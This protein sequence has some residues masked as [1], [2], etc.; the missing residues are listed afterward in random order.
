MEKFDR[1]RIH[2]EIQLKAKPQKNVRG[3]LVRR[4][5]RIAERS[6]KNG[7]EFVAEH[8]DRT[9]GKCDAFAQEFIGAP[10][11]FDKLNLSACR[12]GLRDCA[13]KP[14]VGIDD[15]ANGFD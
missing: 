11:E 15:R 7:V 6:E 10:I 4:N 12:Q 14:G 5:A 2:K 3:M 8:F 9:S 13:G 1:A